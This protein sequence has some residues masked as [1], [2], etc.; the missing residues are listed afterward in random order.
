MP[1]F[2]QTTM[3]SMH[4]FDF[5]PIY[6]N[7]ILAAATAAAAAAAAAAQS[8]LLE[9]KV[10][11]TSNQLVMHACLPPLCLHCGDS[12]ELLPWLHAPCL[13]CMHNSFVVRITGG[14]ALLAPSMFRCVLPVMCFTHDLCS[15]YSVV[16][17]RLP[18]VGHP[19]FALSILG[20]PPC[21]AT[22]L[23]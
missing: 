17:E 22:F 14:V 15:F 19:T 3:F 7:V 8:T 9:V 13:S 23:C 18:A 2:R 4:H 6:Y 21:N 16:H 12:L 11:S 20:M 10:S 1:T 5:T